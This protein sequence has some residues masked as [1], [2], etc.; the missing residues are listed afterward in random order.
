MAKVVIEQNSCDYEANINISFPL[1]Y[2]SI[3]FNFIYY[4]IQH[5]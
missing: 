3:L 1:F 5:S 2:L 4:L